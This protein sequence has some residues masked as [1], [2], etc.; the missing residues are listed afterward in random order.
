MALKG[1]KPDGS[2]RSPD[3]KF[4]DLTK[5]EVADLVDYAQ[6]VTPQFHPPHHAPWED[7]H[8][9]AREVWEG[10]GI[11]PAAIEAKNKE[12]EEARAKLAALTA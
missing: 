2:Y 5:E 10:K 1:M 3:E 4:R 12:I 7:H 6:K 11:T 8:P 9:I